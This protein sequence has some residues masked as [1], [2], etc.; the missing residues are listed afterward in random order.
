V[1][2]KSVSF[3]SVDYDESTRMSTRIHSC[4]STAD[5]R[6]MERRRSLG[7]REP[8]LNCRKQS[9]TISNNC[10]HRIC[11]ITTVRGDFCDEMQFFCKFVAQRFTL[12]PSP[13]VLFCF[14]LFHRACASAFNSVVHV[15]VRNVFDLR[16][17]HRR[18]SSTSFCV[19]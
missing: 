15:H 18:D 13:I 9:K 10:E 7:A 8:A 2:V 3:A 5:G 12:R 19:Q 17:H 1:S 4:V 16:R 6:L 14:V 11:F